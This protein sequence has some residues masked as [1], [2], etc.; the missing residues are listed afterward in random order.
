[1]TICFAWVVFMAPAF[2][3]GPE[4]ADTVLLTEGDGYRLVVGADDVDAATFERLCGAA[5]GVA[6]GATAIRCYD[7][8]L[9]LWRDEAYVEF[10]D[11][12]FAVG[13]R[14]RLAELRG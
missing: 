1:M 10:G 12:A 4:V 2:V 7:E 3:S 11:A 9:A 8:A 13:E 14:I 5:R 6:D